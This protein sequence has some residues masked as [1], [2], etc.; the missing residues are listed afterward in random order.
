MVISIVMR[1]T[2]V[3][4][5]GQ[6]ESRLG[7]AMPALRRVLDQQPGFVSVQYLWGAE[8]DGETAQITTWETL[9]DCRRYVR[10]GGAATVAAY[11]DRALPT[12]PHPDGAW[13]RKTF[14]IVEG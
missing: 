7:E 8:D 14:E 11:E 10:E 3:K 4:D 1:K 9:D 2:A 5:R 12:A 13:L 6:W